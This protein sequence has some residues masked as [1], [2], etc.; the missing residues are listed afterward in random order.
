V[1]VVVV[2]EWYP[3]PADPVHG[4]WAHRQALAARDAGAEVRV[5]A[6]RRPVPPIEVLRRGGLAAWLADAPA[7]LKPAR[8][9]S[10]EVDAVP[11]IAPPRPWSYGVW[12]HWAA[13]PLAL[14]LARL[15]RSWPF[16]LLHAHSV[17]PSGFAAALARRWAPAARSPA[18]A[19][20]THGPDVI[21]VHARSGAAR[22]ATERALLQADVVLANSSWAARRSEQLAG[23]A[24]ETRVVHFGAD[25]P[26]S[27]PERHARPTLVT[28]AHLHAR[29]R[30]A[31]VLHA[32]A[33]LTP[34]RRPDYVVIG[35]GRGREPLEKLV[36]RLGLTEQ[37]RFLGQLPN[38]EAL[39]EAWRCHIYVMPSVEEPFGVAY[40]EAMAGGLPAIGTRGEG[41][42]E[43]IAAGGGGMVMVPA[44]DHRA[45]ARELDR[46]LADT[47][48][49]EALGNAARENV[50]RNF[51]WRACGEATVAAYRTALER[52]RR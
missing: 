32:L 42:P 5:L 45:L 12:G 39:A 31:L 14:A 10:I 16:D 6:L 44:D 52:R 19:I 49:L 37:V 20:S 24:L 23:R 21:S 2:A 51:T 25:F 11:F 36:G 35:G 34:D 4:V 38:P 17:T 7:M 50:E 8:L 41:G 46:L 28:V 43:D 18:L 29:K 33:E 40:I 22:R 13:P 26:A 3:T 1:R 15:S 27:A 9:D 47:A 30:H 48:G